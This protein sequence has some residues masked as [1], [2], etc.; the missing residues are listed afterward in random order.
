MCDVIYILVKSTILMFV[1]VNFS[2]M[3]TNFGHI[4][5]VILF[6]SVKWTFLKCR[7]FENIDLGKPINWHLLFF[8]LQEM[9]WPKM[10][11]KK[12]GLLTVSIFTVLLSKL[13]HAEHSGEKSDISFNKNAK[14]GS[15]I[16]DESSV[17]VPLEGLT[18][19]L[20]RDLNP[21][22]SNTSESL[23]G[24]TTTRVFTSRYR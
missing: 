21:C 14:Q 17:P 3:F 16:N 13:I 23:C 15:Q 24:I 19:S 20:K 8:L 12:F 5:S 6:E 18:F 1:V 22:H 9:H 4:H 11:S 2:I 7:C 10:D